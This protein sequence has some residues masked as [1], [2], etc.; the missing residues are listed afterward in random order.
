MNAKGESTRSPVVGRMDEILRIAANRKALHLGCVGYPFTTER[1]E[2]LLH[3]KLTRVACELWG[4]DACAEGIEQLRPLKS[5][6][7]IVRTQ[8]ECRR[9]DVG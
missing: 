3:G 9:H 1:G 5:D 4:P 7:L 6:G 8:T 2:D